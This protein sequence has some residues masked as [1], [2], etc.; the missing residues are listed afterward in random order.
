MGDHHHDKKK[1]GRDDVL[2]KAD[3][4]SGNGDQP[5]ALDD[6]KL[7]KWVAERAFSSGGYPYDEPLD[8]DI[9]ETALEK[10]QIELVKLQTWAIAE[11]RRIVVVF[12]G[13]DAAGKGSVIGAFRQYMSPRRTRV[14]ALPKPSEAETGQWYFQR[15]V[16]H[17]PTRGEVVMFDRSWYNRAGV[18][19]VMGFCTPEQTELFLKETP[20]FEDMI[21]DEGIHLVK[22]YFDV[23]REMQLSRFHDRRHDPLKVWK[24]S[25]IDQA[26]IDKY[27]DYTRAR[28][29][30]LERTHTDEA[31]W[32]IGLGN[33]KRRLKLDVIRHVLSLFDY[34]DKDR[35]AIGDIDEKVLGRGPAFFNRQN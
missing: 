29:R 23:G 12:E 30:M 27:D 8:D 26:A 33:D 24:I 31:P 32:V 14:V 25:S 1:A 21:T 16:A 20:R 5:F 17:M 4:K 22:F 6:P 13:R 10:L 3:E 9:F 11:G 19:P 7:P 28:D 35:R 18:E 15:Y 34:P 2:A